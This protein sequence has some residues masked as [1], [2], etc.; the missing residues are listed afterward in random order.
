MA[1]VV[2]KFI[3][4][5]DQLVWAFDDESVRRVTT[6]VLYDPRGT[7]VLVPDVFIALDALPANPAVPVWTPAPGRHFRL[8]RI[9]IAANCEGNIRLMDGQSGQIIAVVVAAAHAA[10]WQ[11]DLGVGYRSQEAGSALYALAPAPGAALSGLLAGIEEGPGE[12]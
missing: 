6:A 1:R 9:W 7:P 10:P 4:A 12:Y 8:M 5:R 2:R 11:I 3:D